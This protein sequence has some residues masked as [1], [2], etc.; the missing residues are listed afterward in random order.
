MPPVYRAIN[1]C[2]SII[3]CPIIFQFV[4]TPTNH[5]SRRGLFDEN[6]S[7]WGS[8]VIEGKRDYKTDKSDVGT[9]ASTFFFAGDTA[10]CDAFK[11]IGRKFGP[12]DI[13][14]IPIG[15]SNYTYKGN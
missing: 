13:S 9:P 6:L 15:L 1:S 8:W 4:F 5:Y 10:Y 3:P 2:F 12:I 11:Q 14:A 7:L